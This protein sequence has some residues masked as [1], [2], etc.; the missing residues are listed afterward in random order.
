M[1][2]LDWSIRKLGKDA[3]L[4]L[5]MIVMGNAK[6]GKALESKGTKNHAGCPLMHK[7][8]G[9][10]ESPLCPNCYSKNILNAHPPV[11]NVIESDRVDTPAEAIRLAANSGKSN[12]TGH[13][14][15]P[16]DILRVYGLTDFIPANMPMLRL[17]AKTYR[18][19]IISKTLWFVQK[20]REHI[21]ELA[22]LPGVNISL[23]LNKEVAPDVAKVVRDFE[24]FRAK[25]K[26]GKNVSLNYTFSTAWRETGKS[27]YEPIHRIA[28][29]RVYHYVGKDKTELA[30][31][32]GDAGVCGL[33]DEQ[34]ERRPAGNTGPHA[35]CR[36]CNFCRNDAPKQK[37]MGTRARTTPLKEKS[38]TL[39]PSVVELVAEVVA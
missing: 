33:L 14:V 38:L 10:Y 3:D 35:S 13:S 15:F 11:R 12:L 37:I 28:G 24:A 23:S 26:L 29:I 9:V 19:D 39:N 36:N 1:N 25:H 22:K 32:I 17:M 21:P 16:G 34:G 27:D 7:V 8:E 31:L 5:G 2:M 20:F 4:E 18:L 30:R 6:T